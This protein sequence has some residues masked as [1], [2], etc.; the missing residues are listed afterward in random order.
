MTTDADAL[1]LTERV[2]TAITL[3]ESHFREFKSALDGPPNRKVA[4]DAKL[5]RRDIGETL[6]AFS[7][8]DGGEL[9]VGVE[10][11]GRVTG[12]PHA[13][14]V[15]ESFLGAWKTH[16][17]ADTPIEP[18]RVAQLDL[19]GKVV[20]YFGVEKGTAYI[21]L[22]Q[23]GRCLQRRDRE[24]IPVPS[25]QIRFERQE[26][27]SREYDR[28]YVDG[29]DAA[30]LDIPA[31][32][33]MA[34]QL[35]PGMS[36]EKLL[37]LLDL[38]EFAGDRVRLRRAAVLLLARDI[39]RWHPRCEVRI[40]RVAGTELRSGRDYNVTADK[41]VSGCIVELLGS[42]W[43][44]LRPYL[45]ETRLGPDGRFEEQVRYPE[46]ACRE[47]LTNAIA[48]R[49]YS[50]EGRA[51]EVYV[52]D[53]RL[54]VQSPGALLSTVTIQ[55][56]KRLEGVHQSRNTVI[57]RTLR[58]LGYMREMGEGFRRI[59]HLMR[60]HDLVEPDIHAD[61]QSFVVSLRHQS[62]F[63]EDDQR[64]IA[65][66][67]GFDLQREEEKVLLLG[68]NGDPV[69]VQQIMHALDLVDTEDYRRIILGL[70]QK[71]LLRGITKSFGTRS[72]NS[73][74]WYVVPPQDANRFLGELLAGAT[75]V[76]SGAPFGGKD[77]TAIDKFRSSDSPYLREQGLRASFLSLGMINGRGEPTGRLRAL[78]ERRGTG[79]QASPPTEERATR[80][81]GRLQRVAKEPVGRDSPAR[82]DVVPPGD[83][84]PEILDDELAVADGEPKKLFVD[85]L[86]F[87]AT[88]DE[89]RP[90]FDTVGA[91]EEINVPQRVDSPNRNRGYAFVTMTSAA[92]AKRAREALEGTIVGGRPL[93][94]EWARS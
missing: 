78:I 79:R 44:E 94:L 28:S 48:H 81:K 17:H 58:E 25:E 49:D 9:L 67:E 21:H 73:P 5:I 32:E 75:A 41:H 4:R 1:T 34:E 6:V 27:V 31:L 14:E 91:V 13:S 84:V 61:D 72:R 70:Q 35:A 2:R 65:A 8:A 53:D 92:D 40:L 82:D 50:I 71:G 26:R 69:S 87:T 10:D 88:P 36:P 29:G 15:T 47:A 22:T 51:I 19:D 93:R 42:S 39:S 3:G 64:W 76:Y 83:E 16:I 77:F 86:P 59:F 46:D 55:G 24:S 20:I 89:L 11:D 45:V 62:V 37:Q 43:E 33:R 85:N 12:V 90:L 63:S 23:D 68:R 18:P 7:N 54:E 74:R 57:A 80:P 66:Y 52:F 56:I 30:A 38:A 60:A